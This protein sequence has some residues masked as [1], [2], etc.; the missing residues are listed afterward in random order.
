MPKRQAPFPFPVAIHHDQGGAFLSHLWVG[1]PLKEGHRLSYSLRG[2]HDNPIVESFF[3]RF[4][5]ENG[6]LFLEAA[7]FIELKE[8][9]RQRLA[10]YNELRL[11]SGLV[12]Q[13]PTGALRQA[14]EQAH[15][16]STRQVQLQADR[17]SHF[18][19]E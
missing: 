2:P 18:L 16:H 1:S 11:H 4:K 3:S 15:L 10:Y 6:D 14:L 5:Q 9:I 7:S 12:Y 17:A 19:N 8:V 13:T